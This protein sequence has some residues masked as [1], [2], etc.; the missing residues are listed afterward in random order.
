MAK[1]KPGTGDERA[2]SYVLPR[3]EFR[4][5]RRRLDSRVRAVRRWLL[6]GGVI[7][8]VAFS[9]LAGYETKVA[10]GADS[11]A[12]TAASASVT[13]AAG[14]GFFADQASPSL[15]AASPTT[16]TA[17]AT[18]TPT[19]TATPATTPQATTASATATATTIATTTTVPTVAPTSVAA[20]PT[21]PSS[22]VPPQT[23]SRTHS[24][25]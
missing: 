2:L 6:A 16:A 10:S 25:N 22:D 7:G 18:V 8:T 12:R 20:P 3:W 14:S 21:A 9:G 1:R 15:G 13:Q 11:G 23:Q 19:A 17:T 24:S 4:R 5:H